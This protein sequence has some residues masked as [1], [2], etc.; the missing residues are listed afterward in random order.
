MGH[1]IWP[2]ILEAVAG[3]PWIC[4]DPQDH[5]PDGSPVP[6]RV[7]VYDHLLIL[8]YRFYMMLQCF[9]TITIV[10]V[11]DGFSTWYEPFIIWCIVISYCYYSH[12]SPIIYLFIIYHMMS[13]SPITAISILSD[14][15]SPKPVATAIS[16]AHQVL[17][18]ASPWSGSADGSKHEDLIITKPPKKI[19]MD[20]AQL[21]RWHR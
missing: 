9:L 21:P 14:G 6:C 2:T 12:Y 8:F 5:C 17:R 1:G 20:V 10:L 18:K 11:H 15:A 16:S 7:P 4:E 13:Y 19:P 3:W